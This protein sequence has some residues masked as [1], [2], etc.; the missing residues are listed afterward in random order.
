[1]LKPMFNMP[2]V[3]NRVDGFVFDKESRMRL[4]LHDIGVDFM[5]RARANKTFQDHTGN[6]KSSI[7][8]TI[9]L[10]GKVIDE[11]F[12]GE[13]EGITQAQTVVQEL[14]RDN[15]EGFVLIG[16]AGM[17]YAAAVESK[18]YDVITGSTPGASELLDYYKR[19][20]QLL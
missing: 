14:A 6:L 8:Y 9:L 5:N 10:D 20:L 2:Q 12:E 16:L 18:G 7:G 13:T 19:E 17:E 1:M 3:G 4:A 11:G 15:P